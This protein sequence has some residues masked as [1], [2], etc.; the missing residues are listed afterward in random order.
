MSCRRSS[1]PVERRSNDLK[2]EPQTR[3]AWQ[4]FTF[5]GVAAFANARLSRLLLVQL[6]FAIV[7]SASI[8]WFCASAY[9]PVVTRTIEQLPETAA[10]ENGTLT[11]FSKPLVVET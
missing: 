9:G 3:A 8:V 6:I 7:A 11:G 4:P 10:L 5:G 2:E 1:I